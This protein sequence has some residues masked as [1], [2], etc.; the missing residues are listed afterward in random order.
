VILSPY[1]QT[2]SSLADVRKLDGIELVYDVNRW[3]KA[4]GVLLTTMR[5]FKGLEADVGVL[6]DLP[7]PGSVAACS[8]A[9]FYVGSSRAKHLLKIVSSESRNDLLEAV[10]EA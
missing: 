7:K 5:S 1:S 10:V 9:D 2:R 8:V 6:I 4:E 3:R